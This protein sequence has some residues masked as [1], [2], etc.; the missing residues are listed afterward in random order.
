MTQSKI[1]EVWINQ[2]ADWTT[3]CYCKNLYINQR[4]KS[5][6]RNFGYQHAGIPTQSDFRHLITK[7]GIG[8]SPRLQQTLRISSL[9]RLNSKCL[10]GY[11]WYTPSVHICKTSKTLW[12]LCYGT[13]TAFHIDPRVSTGSPRNLDTKSVL[14]DSHEWTCSKKWGQGTSQHVH[15]NQKRKMD[16]F[17]GLNTTKT[18]HYVESEYKKATAMAVIRNILQYIA[19]YCN[20]KIGSSRYPEKKDGNM[21]CLNTTWTSATINEHRRNKKNHWLQNNK[22]Q[23]MIWLNIDRTQWKSCLC[24]PHPWVTPLSTCPIQTTY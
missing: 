1:A 13:N 2:S 24:I 11:P 5:R 6:I 20:I 17:H 22:T 8:L 18:H 19:M 10:L 14:S 7:L 16:F 15:P 23:H 21:T 3:N 9:A 4:W 12:I